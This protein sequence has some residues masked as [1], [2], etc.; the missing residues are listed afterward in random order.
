VFRDS[1]PGCSPGR[2]HVSRTATGSLS[3]VPDIS[4]YPA[5]ICPR[6]FGLARAAT[7]WWNSSICV[8]LS[9]RRA[10]RGHAMSNGCAEANTR[11]RRGIR[12]GR[13]RRHRVG[14]GSFRDCTRR[15]PRGHANGPRL[16]VVG[17]PASDPSVRDVTT[18]LWSASEG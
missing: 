7:I 4:W 16:P 9:A 11:K 10:L 3:G 12:A 8:S 17:K 1:P 2:S 14:W 13:A 6:T 15:F 18:G 5:R